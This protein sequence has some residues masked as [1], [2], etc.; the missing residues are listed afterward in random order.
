MCSIIYL[1]RE[2]RDMND[3]KEVLKYCPNYYNIVNFDFS[4][5]DVISEKLITIYRNYIFTVD[6]SNVEDVNRITELDRV[7]YNYIQDFLF[8]STLQKEIITVKVKKDN[9]VLRSLVDVIIRIFTN[10]EE[11]TTRKIYISKWI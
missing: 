11:Y 9:N 6:L 1:N 8:R 5:N 10:Y 7:L 4:D 3:N 2:S